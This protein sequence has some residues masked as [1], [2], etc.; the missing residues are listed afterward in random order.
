VS[1][2]LSRMPEGR[3]GRWLAAALLALTL[4]LFWL[5]VAAPLLDW[6][7]ARAERLAERRLMLAHMAQV[8]A[9][10]PALRQV[11]GKAG[12]AAPPPTA[13]LGGETDAIAGATLQSAVQDMAA[14]AGATLASAEALPGEQQG[15]FRRIGLRVTLRGD[16]P[17]LMGMLQAVDESPLRLLVDDLQLHATAQP[18]PAGPQSLETSL[19]VLGYRPGRENGTRGDLRADA[20]SP[21]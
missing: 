5:A 2:A 19:V 4:G 16:W 7:A 21:G 17:V 6:H 1:G 10:L 9:T 20:G 11:S 12:S 15:A 3:R 18:Q 14:S 13:L 8:A